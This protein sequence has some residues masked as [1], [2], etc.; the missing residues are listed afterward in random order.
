MT[1][2]IFILNWYIKNVPHF[3]RVKTIKEIFDRHHY[4]LYLNTDAPVDLMLSGNHGSLK[5]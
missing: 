3:L 1:F 5:K 2:M 4:P